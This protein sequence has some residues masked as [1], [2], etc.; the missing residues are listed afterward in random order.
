MCAEPARLHAEML[1]DLL[2]P[3]VE[4][5]YHMAVPTDPDIAPQILRRHGVI[6]LGHLHVAVTVDL[7]PSLLEGRE[8]ARR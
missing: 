3:L 2:Q 6:G 7:P 4:D 8:P 1:G 5:P